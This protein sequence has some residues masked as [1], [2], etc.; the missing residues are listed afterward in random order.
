MPIQ[1]REEAPPEARRKEIFQALVEA[2][3]QDMGVARSRKVIA[4]RF[5]I[6]ESLV[7][8]IEE[9]GLQLEWPPL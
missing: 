5:G 9:E 1:D 3:D 7:K 8:K 2:Q 4:D 6:T